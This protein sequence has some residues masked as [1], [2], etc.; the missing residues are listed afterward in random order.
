MADDV[1]QSLS[2]LGSII[3]RNYWFHMLPEKRPEQALIL[4]LGGGS[5]A[6]IMFA[7]LGQTRIVGV[8]DD[9]D[10]VTL[11]RD[12]GWLNIP[13][14][15]I[16]HAEAFAYLKRCA[17]HFDYVAIDLF[18]GAI[19]DRQLTTRP[20]WRAVRNILAPDGLVVINVFRDLYHQHHLA[21]VESVLT[22]TN[23][24]TVDAN[25]LIYARR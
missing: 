14:L 4:G 9:S 3:S 19:C 11:A 2:P 17:E 7:H 5:L 21:A 20:F 23:T 16:V 12:A 22:V 15:E 10:V 13:G 1:L 8:D 18:R 24:M 6:R 25:F